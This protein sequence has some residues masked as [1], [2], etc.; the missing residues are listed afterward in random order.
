MDC[1][2]ETR[3]Y[4]SVYKHL[5][6]GNKE[7][8]VINP[9]VAQ[10]RAQFHLDE[11]LKLLA[12]DL[13]QNIHILVNQELLIATDF[14]SKEAP[15]ILALR[16]LDSKSHTPFPPEE[17]TVFL[18]IA[19]E[20]G[21]AE[22]AYR[23][24][25]CYAGTGKFKSL[26]LAAVNY[27]A[28]FSSIERRRL[29][30]YYFEQAIAQEHQPAIEEAIM[31]YS[32]GRGLIE[33]DVNQLV[34]LC[35]QLVERNYYPAML[36]YAAWLAGMTVLGEEPLASAVSLP[37]NQEKSLQLL[38]RI[39]KS[40]NL[41]LAQHALFLICCGIE[42]D[43][44]CMPVS[45]LVNRLFNEAMQGNQLLAL[46]LAWYCLPVENRLLMP[47]LFDKYELQKLS[48]VIESSEKQAFVLLNHVILGDDEDIAHAGNEIL[49]HVF[50]KCFMDEDGRINMMEV[51]DIVASS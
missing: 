2:D 21:H 1:I 14:G 35:E 16:V 25:C 32:Y 30:V 8:P 20:R 33:K 36:G 12:T 34:F 18:K 9:D 23:L 27:L 22:A 50:G 15:F 11:A 19:S 51:N 43:A 10:R 28:D 45:L 24:A 4:R 47:T 6:I 44:W 5:R 3:R 40:K 41:Q 13:D 42:R 37:R 48:D 39:A 46:Y 26:E 29:A 38:L 17:A 49:S 7:Y 31:A